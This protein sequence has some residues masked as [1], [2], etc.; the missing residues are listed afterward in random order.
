MLFTLCVRFLIPRHCV[1]V[2]CNEQAIN[3]SIISIIMTHDRWQQQQQQQQGLVMLWTGIR[4]KEW[5]CSV[6]A[7][8]ATSQTLFSFQQRPAILRFV[9]INCLSLSRPP[10]CFQ[11]AIFLGSGNRKKIAIAFCCNPNIS[12]KKLTKLA[13]HKVGFG[14][15]VFNKVKPRFA[16]SA[17]KVKWGMTTEPII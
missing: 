13:R 12:F 6:I 10:V 9:W 1:S 4:D 2:S 16:G 15:N 8:Q 3:I 14:G 7:W 5:A 11:L 17:T